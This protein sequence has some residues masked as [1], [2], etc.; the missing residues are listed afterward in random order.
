MASADELMEKHTTCAAMPPIEIDV[1]VEEPK[2][3]DSDDEFVEAPTG[4][5][6]RLIFL[7]RDEFRRTND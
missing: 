3:D 1:T 7:E 4:A 6:V 2:C 5:S